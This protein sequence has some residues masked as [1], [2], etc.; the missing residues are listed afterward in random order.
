M[1]KNNVIIHIGT[2][3]L[4][5][6]CMI[7]VLCAIRSYFSKQMSSEKHKAKIFLMRFAR[8][9][10]WRFNAKCNN[11]EKTWEIQIT[12]VP[13]NGNV[14]EDRYFKLTLNL[15]SFNKPIIKYNRGEL[16]FSSLSVRRL[17]SFQTLLFHR[18]FQCV[19]GSLSHVL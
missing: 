3:I 8:L 1:H 16:P 9:H 4:N 13:L 17:I 19:N 11:F 5:S 6:N 12:F 15:E 10:L 18:I 14:A 7:T 2:T